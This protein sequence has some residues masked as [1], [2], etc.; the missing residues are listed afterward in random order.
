[1]LGEAADAAAA[2]SPLDLLP[3]PTSSPAGAVTDSPAPPPVAADVGV[4]E[5]PPLVVLPD[6]SVLGH[7]E[8]VVVVAEVGDRWPATVAE[9]GPN[10]STAVVLDASAAGGPNALVE[11][12]RIVACPGEQRSYSCAAQSQ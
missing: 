10:T 5:A 12:H 3:A 11:G 7:E 6:L 2:P 1:V 9:E 8:R 4:V